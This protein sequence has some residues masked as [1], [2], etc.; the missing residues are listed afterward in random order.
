MI[1]EAVL[2][3]ITAKEKRADFLEK[4]REDGFFDDS[5]ENA[6]GMDSDINSYIDPELISYSEKYSFK[7]GHIQKTNRYKKK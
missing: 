2:S 6:L 7:I 1:R 5:N 3:E 4:Q